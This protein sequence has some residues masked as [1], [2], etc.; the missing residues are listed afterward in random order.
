MQGLLSEGVLPGILRE[1]YVGRRSGLLR[2]ARGEERYGVRFVNGNIVHAESNQPQARLGEIMVGQGLLREPDL[3][4]AQE[5]VARTRRRMGE[6]L[7]EM[8][9]LNWERLDDAL[10]VQVRELLLQVFSW[11]DGRYELEET[12]DARAHATLKL[13]TGEMIL[14]AVRRVKSPGAVRHALG[15]LDR[16]VILSTDPLLRFQR[17]TLTADDG[18]VLSRVD[19]IATAREIQAMTPRPAEEVQRSL[20]GLVCTGLIEYLPTRA[21]TESGAATRADVLDAVLHLAGRT[22]YEVLEVPR[23]ATQATIMA[24]YY[25]QAK[26][27]HPDAHHAPGLTDLRDQ[28]EAV[29]QRVSAAYETLRRPD[30][31]AAYD[32]MLARSDGPAAPASGDGE[33][34]VVEETLQRVDQL[35]NE[36]SY[37]DAI[38]TLEALVPLAQGRLL[39]RTRMLL[40]KAYLKSPRGARLAEAEL[41]AV[42]Q[43]DPASVDAHLMLGRLYRDRGLRERAAGAF[44][45]AL[46]IE[47]QSRA[48]FAEL[49]SL[50][51]PRSDGLLGRILKR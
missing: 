29:F 42:L 6:V 32:Q 17:L 13:S 28:L 35:L 39:A 33:G 26:R 19:G 11:T 14:E 43:Q 1:I 23:D 8:G 7:V 51:E 50:G 18:F 48:A 3:R 21:E 45:R 34:R 25:R 49:E 30:Q 38:H 36:T 22:H 31:R 12:S 41:S 2:F 24:A 9:V 37:A 15:D 20:L 46:E 16:V 47:P 10:A 27:F 4:R 40:A 5:I 44:K